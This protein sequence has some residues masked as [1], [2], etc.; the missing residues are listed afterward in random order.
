MSDY[1][2]RFGGVA[3]LFGRDAAG[4]LARA[5]VCVVGIGGVGSWA[6]EAL[7]RSGLGQL[8][9]VDL[10]DVCVTNVN[11]QL[12]ALDGAIGRPEVALMAERLRAIN[13]EA[14]IHA[15]QDFFTADN[16]AELLAPRFDFVVDAIDTPRLK[17]LLVAACCARGIR[18]ICSGG[19]GGRRDSTRVR[20]GDLSG[21]THDRL[22]AEVRRRLRREHGF[23]PAGRRMGIDGVFSD[24]PPVFP[25]RDGGICEAPEP[26]S[27]Q[28]LDC[29]SGLGTACFVTGAFGFALAARV[30]ARLASDPA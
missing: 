11:R 21:S 23:P 1:A 10:D 8:T 4:R 20:T 26:G 7:G 24:E 29:R 6:A 9:L 19:A 2:E 16:A 18:V 30:V 27:G 3:R 12:P 17:A 22:L 25:S 13:P 14:V 28:R 5:S 15:R